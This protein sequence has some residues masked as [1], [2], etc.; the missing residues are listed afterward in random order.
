MLLPT[1]TSGSGEPTARGGTCEDGRVS[2]AQGTQR[3]GRYP[4]TTN[5]LIGSLI[6]S[7][8]LIGAFVA[9]R[10]V[11]SKDLEVK[12]T[13]VDYLANVGFAQQAGFDPVYPAEL[14]PGWTATSLDYTPGNRP[15]WGIGMLTDEGTF[16]GIRQENASVD[17]LLRTYVDE[18]P[19]EG[20]TLDVPG[21][22]APTWRTFTDS[23][24]D[25]AYAAQVG[26]DTVLVYGSASTEDQRLLL[27]SLTTE[28]RP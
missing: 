1:P 14:P 16:V 3:P 12:P 27:G 20:G 11:F 9:L 2:E 10:G 7:L 8:V 23:G 17:D 28:P 13:T 19:A 22:V 5:G 21:T 24:G 26:D 15:A 18:D 4:R 6:V 25:Q